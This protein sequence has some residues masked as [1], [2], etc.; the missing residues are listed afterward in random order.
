MVEP[1]LIARHV[2]SNAPSK[3]AGVAKGVVLVLIAFAPF[4][5]SAGLVK[6]RLWS[7]RVVDNG[8]IQP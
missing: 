3:L 2:E 6:K 1:A 8:S 5:E 4:T 7:K